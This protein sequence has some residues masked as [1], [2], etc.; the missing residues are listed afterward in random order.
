MHTPCDQQHAWCELSEENCCEFVIVV[1]VVGAEIVAL[2][3]VTFPSCCFHVYIFFCVL[4]AG[5]R[6]SRCK[7]RWWGGGVVW[8]GVWLQTNL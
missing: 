8:W 4:L 5:L 6:D 2:A 3:G 7:F 1:V